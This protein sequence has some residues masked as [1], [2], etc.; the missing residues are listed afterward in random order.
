MGSIYI[1]IVKDKP[2]AEW[3]FNDLNGKILKQGY[4]YLLD[5][6]V[7]K[8]PKQHRDKFPI[9]KFLEFE[10][11]FYR[12][13]KLLLDTKEVKSLKTEF[14]YVIDILNK[15]QFL[16]NV[17]ADLILEYLSKDS[18]PTLTSDKIIEELL[19]IKQLIDFADWNNCYI[20]I[21]R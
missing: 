15:R 14:D 3:S 19:E 5:K 9:L 16:E 4:A 21:D 20:C 11:G 2:K 10:G 6:I 18:Y 17:D 1:S 8:L 7:E 12:G 13:E